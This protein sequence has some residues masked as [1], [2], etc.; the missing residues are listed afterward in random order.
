MFSIAPVADPSDYGDEDLFHTLRHVAGFLVS[1]SAGA[2]HAF[3]APY[4]ERL[5][6][7]LQ[8]LSSALGVR[9]PDGTD[10]IAGTTLITQRLSAK[11]G[12]GLA[13][14][15]IEDYV[16]EGVAI[17][18]EA[19]HLHRREL[20]GEGVVTH[21]F[22]ADGGVPKR[23]VDEVGVEWRGIVG[24]GQAHRQHHGRP[25]QALSLFS[26]ELVDELRHEG[27][28]VVAGGVG[29]NITTT[30]LAWSSLQPG[31][32][33][34]IGT[35][36]AEISCFADPC[37]QIAHNFVGRDFNRI[38]EDRIPGS[39]RRYAWVLEPGAIRVGDAIVVGSSGHAH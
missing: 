28:P 21:L 19:V 3:V 38:D 18:R 2:D 16:R 9:I 1:N 10:A 34:R 6:D 15:A 17:A 33:V 30:G 23:P 31:V 24:D 32:Q 25:F 35:V 29:E 36:V 26:T 14:S 37:S 12:H 13:R 8:R 5:R 20:R 11:G 39:G 4:D 27:H 7:A 22:R